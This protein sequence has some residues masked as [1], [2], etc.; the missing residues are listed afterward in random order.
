MSLLTLGMLENTPALK[1]STCVSA[2]TPNT[3]WLQGCRIII[4]IVVNELDTRYTIPKTCTLAELDYSV[5]CGADIRV[6]WVVSKQP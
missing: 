5:F 2:T 1:A 6:K 4:D 3:T